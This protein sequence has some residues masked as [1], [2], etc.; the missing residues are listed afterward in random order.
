MRELV[1]LAYF[2]PLF[3]WIVL[4]SLWP[5]L[6]TFNKDDVN[7]T[8]LPNCDYYITAG[9]YY[10][11]NHIFSYDNPWIVLL[12]AIPYTIH[13]MV[14]F[15]FGIV[16]SLESYF[17]S[18]C[19]TSLRWRM[20]AFYWTFGVANV[21]GVLIQWG[22]PTAPPWWYD[23]SPEHI[24]TNMQGNP[25]V[26]AILDQY[27]ENNFFVNLY[28]KSTI[29]YGS[30]PSLHAAWPVIACYFTLNKRH[31]WKRIV[32]PIYLLWIWWAAV[33]SKHHFI[34]DILGG[35]FV[36]MIA[37]AAHRIF[38]TK[39][40]CILR[41]QN[42]MVPIIDEVETKPPPYI[43]FHDCS[44]KVKTDSELYKTPQRREDL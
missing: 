41:K 4:I 21:L 9:H 23:Y 34:M 28:S 38:L 25:A 32:W 24:V 26:F 6:F 37:I 22:F 29:V 11:V 44:K 20:C 14:P 19:K 40:K 18:Q 17:K 39:P 43:Y 13:F 31:F 5:V 3:V 1:T 30:Y 33:Y 35:I 36:S 8:F 7:L 2:T 10:F 16:I 12:A 42:G 27:F 15:I